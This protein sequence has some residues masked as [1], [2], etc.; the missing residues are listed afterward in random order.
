VWRRVP[1]DDGVR[2]HRRDLSVAAVDDSVG[3]S[4]VRTPAG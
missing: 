3:A 4:L 2:R 1:D